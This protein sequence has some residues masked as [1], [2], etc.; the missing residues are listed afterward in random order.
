MFANPVKLSPL[1]LL[2]IACGGTEPP[3]AL[4]PI[5]AARLLVFADPP[6][7][8]FEDS[9]EVQ[10]STNEPAEIYYTLD[11][12]VPGDH[13]ERYQGAIKIEAQTLLTFV[14]RADDGSWSE[15]VVEL[16]KRER[17]LVAPGIAR[18]ALALSNDNL[19]F[20]ARPGEGEMRARVLIRSVGTEDTMLNF[21]G[22]GS[23]GGQFY[24]PE[25]FRLV[26]QLDYP[27]R[28]PPGATLEL[29]VAYSPRPILRSAGLFIGSNDIRVEDGLH[30]V[31]LTGRIQPF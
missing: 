21:A 7:Q 25:V 16:Y 19:F 6:G 5:Q 8:S 13:A 30:L 28:M 17:A 29:E 22:I 4:A 12:T 11:G 14:A 24:E 27:V 15:S 26:T 3:E 18:R 10:L 2:A 31:N 9:L 1:A 23:T 20:G